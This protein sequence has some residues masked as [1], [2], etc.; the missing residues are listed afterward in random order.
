[1]VYPQQ[2]QQ[3]LHTLMQRLGLSDDAAIDW[4]LLDIALT[5]PSADRHANYER[6]EFVG[7][8]V[9][10][11]LASEILLQDYP[12]DPV[13]DYAAIRSI[14]VSDR[15]LAQWGERYGLDRYLVMA[16]G[17]MGRSHKFVRLADVFEAVLGALY[18]STGDMRLIA[19][20]LTPLIQQ[21]AAEVRRDPAFYNYKDALQAWTQGQHQAL[22][23]Y[24]V[25]E[26]PESTTPQ[27]RF[28]AE[29]WLHQTALGQGSGPSKK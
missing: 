19:E 16:G 2:R 13:G 3:Q 7:D 15:V 25:Q 28:H 14:V 5:H 10:R 23:T 18:K 22:P 11:L 17:Q 1:M 20:W 24:Q 8:A 4:Q 6:L 27:T 29:V 26:Q 21:Q 9:V 12:D